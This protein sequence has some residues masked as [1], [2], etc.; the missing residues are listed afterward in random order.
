MNKYESDV[1]S[2]CTNYTGL[3]NEIFF[4]RIVYE[5]VILANFGFK[6][7]NL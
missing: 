5:Q 3:Q 7:S 1:Y 2:T 6:I 4:Q